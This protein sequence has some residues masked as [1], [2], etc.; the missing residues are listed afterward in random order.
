[1]LPSAHYFSGVVIFASMSLIGIIPNNFLHLLLIVSCSI[2][3][4]FDLLISPSH[5]DFFIHTPLF[6]LGVVAVIVLVMPSGWIVAP[7]FF[8]HLFLDTIDW[9]LMALYPISREKYGIKLLGDANQTRFTG[10]F[11]SLKEYI[12]DPRLLRIEIV[13]MGLS[14]VAL[15]GVAVCI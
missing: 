10:L 2:L 12:N 3:P 8:V 1:M 7:P 14:L 9:G 13:I 4:D 15:L 5:R 11:A 6:W